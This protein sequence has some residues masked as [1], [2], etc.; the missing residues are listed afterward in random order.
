M[1]PV[2]LIAAAATGTS[3]AIGAATAAIIGATVSTAV[4]T[5]IGSGIIAGAITLAQ[6]GSASDAL[7][8]AVIGGVSSGI[9]ASI[10]ATVGSAASSAAASAG[11]SSIAEGFGQV[12]GGA[13]SGATTAATAAYMGGSSGKDALKA[14]LQGAVMG[15]A[16]AGIQ[17][18]A[19]KYLPAAWTGKAPPPGDAPNTIGPE[20][21]HP[22]TDVASANLSTSRAP[23]DI[24]DMYSMDPMTYNTA[25]A[26]QAPLTNPNSSVL[27]S[28]Q[29]NTDSVGYTP[30][31]VYSP[32][33]QLSAASPAPAAAPTS[34]G[35]AQMAIDSVTNPLAVGALVLGTRSSS[36]AD[37]QKQQDQQNQQ[38][39][40]NEQQAAIKQQFNEPLPIY[41]MNREYIDPNLDWQRYGRDTGQNQFFSN[42][43][44]TKQAKR[45]GLMHFAD[46]GYAEH[47]QYDEYGRRKFAKA[48]E[49]KEGYKLYDPH[50]AGLQNLFFGINDNSLKNLSAE[51]R[52]YVKQQHNEYLNANSQGRSPLWNA[53]FRTMAKDD[54]YWVK[55]PAYNANSGASSGASTVVDG[56]NKIVPVGAVGEL[57]TRQVRMPTDVDFLQYA[58]Q[59][60]QPSFFTDIPQQG[61][62]KTSQNPRSALQSVSDTAS[63]GFLQGIAPT[64][65][66]EQVTNSPILSTPTADQTNPASFLSAIL[67]PTQMPQYAMGGQVMP[68]NPSYYTYG[69]VPQYGNSTPMKRGGLSS[70]KMN[71]GGNPIS[72]GRT[73]DIPAM[74]SD[75]E[76][77]ID[78]ET[79][80]LLGNGSQDAG[81]KQLD[82]MRQQVRKQKGGALSKGQISPNARSPLAY[83]KQ[84]MA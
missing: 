33:A 81:A 66:M 11:Y 27:M 63:R 35:W 2:I 41:T 54:Y 43:D 42:V 83:L 74:L 25:Q 67:P 29:S 22:T 79:V 4:A 56:S 65:S 8:S 32:L 53:L 64:G 17:L 57:A 72:D 48:G 44:Y 75:G 6:G 47:P 40:Q 18:A 39:Q 59:Y 61:D 26:A 30:P 73:D 82:R 55:D 5:A 15:G 36:L 20:G 71:K 34:P 38:N 28:G 3:A 84:R 46:G 45:G 60:K 58:R 78:A 52:D 37:Q 10:G 51:D 70:V 50:K 23:G 69:Q 21:F 12:I 1:P 7:K 16:G 62:L 68:T 80:A 13:A 77:V 76:Y 49:V 24:S 31:K 19:D 14:G 9:G